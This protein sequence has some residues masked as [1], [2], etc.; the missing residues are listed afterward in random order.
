MNH[1]IYIYQHKNSLKYYVGQTIDV[2]K[3]HS[4]HKCTKGAVLYIDRAIHKYGEDAFMLHTIE[5]WET[6]EDA[7]QAEIAAI[8]FYDSMFPNGYNLAP[9]G[10]VKG[11][12]HTDESKTK[13]KAARAKQVSSG[14]KGKIGVYKRSEEVKKR[15]SIAQTGRHGTTTGRHW[16]NIDGKRTWID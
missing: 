16:K 5:E 6:Q 3:R 15:M 1:Y 4:Q 9:G 10:H 8:K 2:R 12:K 13:I 11:Y 14:M 7:D